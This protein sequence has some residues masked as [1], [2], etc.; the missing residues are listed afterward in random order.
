MPFSSIVMVPLVG[1]VTIVP[2]VTL[3]VYCHSLETVGWG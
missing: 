3:S 1:S 2:P